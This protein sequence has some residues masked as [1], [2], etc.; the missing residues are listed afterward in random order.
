MSDPGYTAQTASLTSTAPQYDWVSQQLRQIYQ[1]LVDNTDT[2]GACWGND[3]QGQA[4][5]GKYCG[6][7]VS[8]IAQLGNT[9]QGTHSMVD[10]ICVWAKNYVHADQA[11]VSSASQLGN[12][13]A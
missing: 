6:P 3:S 8:L 2:E 7:A 4:F 5:G 11:V 10:S 9:Q 12:T 1:K 13:T